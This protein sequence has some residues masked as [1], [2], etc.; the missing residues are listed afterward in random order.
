MIRKLALTSLVAIVI[1]SPWAQRAVLADAPQ[2]DAQVQAFVLLAAEDDPQ[3]L[4]LVQTFVKGQGGHTLHTF[5]DQAVIAQLPASSLQTLAALP[6]VAAVSAQAIDPSAVDR[7]GPQARRLAGVWNS[8]VA[9]RPSASAASLQT[10]VYPDAPH[11]AL[12]APDWPSL[13]VMSAA[14]DSSVKPGYYQTSEYMAGSVAV[15][16]V[17]VES[18]GSIDP[19]TEDWTSD[20]KH[21]VF[22]KIVAALDWWAELEPRAHLS[23]V[24]DDHF[25]VPLPTGVEPIMRP[26]SDERYWIAE[27]MGDLG[28]HTGSYFSRVRNYNDA[29]RT[30]YHTNWAFTIFMVNS[31]HDSDGSFSDGYFAYAYVGGPFM[32]MTYSNGG[33]GPGNMDA[34]AAHET[35]HIFNALDQYAAAGQSCA[36]YSGYLAVQNQNSRYGSCAMNVPSIMRGQI[37][38]YLNHAIDPYAAGQIGWRVSNNNNVLDPLYTDLPITI[39]QVSQNDSSVTVSGTAQIIPYPSPTHPSVTINTLTGVQYRLDEGDWQPATAD[40]GAFDDTFESY[41]LAA[42]GIMPGLHLLQVAA[43]D[44]AGNVSELFAAATIAVLDPVDGGLFTVLDP[45]GANLQ[46]G[47]ELD[48][49]GA[50]Y[51]LEGGTVASVDYRVDSGVWQSASAQDGKY[52]S[53]DEP[54]VISMDWLDIGTHLIEARA[55]DMTGQTEVTFA[56]RQVTVTHA[57][58]TT[59]LPIVVR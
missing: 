26:Y 7:Y 54:F 4:A 39:T 1:L 12:T 59:F 23:F 5:P 28:Y 14:T 38:P 43:R 58:H 18:D 8:L 48:V 10:P 56:S 37:Y 51:Q 35:G 40:D 15:G 19:S 32:V 25:T 36:S 33:Y 3:H 20:Q 11:D 9:A 21:L 22:S 45:P 6:G 46:A 13:G 24:Y 49:T 27:A 41:H 2:A 29:L 55:T 30:R 47:E 17:L 31:T 57:V 50:A 53:G 42:G 16:I 52:D 34:V 44:S